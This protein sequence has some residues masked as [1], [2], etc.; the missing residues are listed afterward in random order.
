MSIS[1]NE[2]SEITSK[3]Y[4]INTNIKII[5]KCIQKHN[6]VSMTIKSYMVQ[7][8]YNHVENLNAYTI[9]NFLKKS[10]LIQWFI[11]INMTW[12]YLQKM[13]AFGETRASSY[14]L[15]LYQCVFYKISKIDT[16]CILTY[17]SLQ[18]V[19]ESMNLSA[20]DSIWRWWTAGMKFSDE[21][22]FLE[23]TQEKFRIQIAA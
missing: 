20:H 11:W 18:V 10:R 12:N 8:C 5:C 2:N 14:V 15:S 3:S 4:K 7:T 23:I 9:L 13:Y 16:S 21:N 19:W 1:Q 6:K 22:H 17:T